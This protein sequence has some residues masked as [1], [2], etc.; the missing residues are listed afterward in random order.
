[1]S[2]SVFVSHCM[3]EEDSPII[4]ELAKRLRGMGI[5]PYLAERDPQSGRSLSARMLERIRSADLV[6]VFWTK[7]GASSEWVNQEVGAARSVGKLVV[8]IVEKGVRVRGLLEGVER[9][10]FDRAVLIQP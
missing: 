6:T 1:M 2:Y 5:E 9:V 10:E 7:R 4:D 8:P 3:V